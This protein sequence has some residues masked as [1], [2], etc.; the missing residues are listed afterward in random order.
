MPRDGTGGDFSCPVCG[1]RYEVDRN[2]VATSKKKWTQ[3]TCYSPTCR[4]RA[5]L[6]VD[7]ELLRKGLG[8]PY[9]AGPVT[10]AMP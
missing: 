6:L 9:N 1:T 8:I 2:K 3:L 10:E 5:R 4:G 7:L